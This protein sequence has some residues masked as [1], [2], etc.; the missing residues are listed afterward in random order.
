MIAA[1]A[2]PIPHSLPTSHTLTFIFPATTDFGALDRALRTRLERID[3]APYTVAQVAQI[4]ATAYPGWPHAPYPRLA[5]AGRRSPRIALQ[6]A[7]NLA[8]RLNTYANES[9]I[10]ALERLFELWGIDDLG[11]S[12][13]DRALLA[14]LH[15]AQQPRGVSYLASRLQTSQDEITDVIE[16]YLSESGLYRTPAKRTDHYR[17]RATVPE[18]SPCG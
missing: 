5:V 13:Q 12:E 8:Q 17:S 16:P 10:Q 11:V 15:E 18:G 1:V 3:L 7:R 14:L 2:V 4:V 9:P 6:R